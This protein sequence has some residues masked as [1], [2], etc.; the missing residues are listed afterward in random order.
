MPTRLDG[1]RAETTLR[2]RAISIQYRVGARGCGVQSVALNGQV[3]GFERQANPHRGGAALVAWKAVLGLLNEG[4]N[5]L[6]IA[7]G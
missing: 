1:L 5:Q 7:I 2:G 6:Q 3:L 4:G